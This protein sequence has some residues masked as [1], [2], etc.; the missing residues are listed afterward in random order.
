MRVI[1]NTF[2][3]YINDLVADIKGLPLT[4]LWLH[5]DLLKKK[6]QHF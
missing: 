6:W 5:Y 4:S 3:H 1:L 2:T